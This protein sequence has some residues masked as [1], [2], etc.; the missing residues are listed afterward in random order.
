MNRIKFEECIDKFQSSCNTDLMKL[1]AIINI[2]ERQ[3]SFE[4]FLSK[5]FQADECTKNDVKDFLLST[6]LTKNPIG[7]SYEN[8]YDPKV[9]AKD[10]NTPLDV[11]HVNELHLLQSGATGGERDPL[12]R[13]NSYE[14]LYKSLCDIFEASSD[15]SISVSSF[16]LS[17][18]ASSI[19]SIHQNQTAACD[20]NL[21]QVNW[22]L[23]RKFYSILKIC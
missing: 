5:L 23:C 14:D 20:E 15:L 6:R 11:N 22:L 19:D 17:S 4:N 18:I 3:C 16:E 2:S 10:N 7:S 13:Y 8:I 1:A 12:H 21:S 9:S